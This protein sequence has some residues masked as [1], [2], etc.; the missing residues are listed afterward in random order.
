MGLA[1]PPWRGRPVI[2][3][4]AV[5]VAIGT[6][7]L[8]GAGAPLQGPASWLVAVRVALGASWLTYLALLGLRAVRAQP[9][10][11][12][13]AVLVTGVLLPRYVR[14]P[15]FGVPAAFAVAITLA[16][17]S[18]FLTDVAR[19]PVTRRYWLGAALLLLPWGIP[20]LS[21]HWPS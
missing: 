8:Q 21:A 12:G 9:I 6:V 2:A 10:G 3:A 4:L 16:A 11:L 18:L 13:R 20:P 5:G 14:D 7:A 15:A 19:V 17:V 1:R